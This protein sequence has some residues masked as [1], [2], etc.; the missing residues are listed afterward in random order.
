[1]RKNKVNFIT[2]GCSKNL[3]DSE[4]IMRQFVAGGYSVVHNPANADGDITVINTCGFIQ[5]AKEESIETILTFGAAKQQGRI[6]RL[7]VIGCLSERYRDQ[8]QKLIPEVDKFYGKF[9]Y[10]QL[11]T[12]LGKPYH[13]ELAGERLLSTPSHY[14][15][16]KIAEG[17]NRKCSYCSIPLITGKYRSRPLDEIINE[18]RTLAA[19]G[20][21]EFQLIAQDLTSYGRDIYRKAALSELLSRLSD[22]SGVQWLRLHYAYPGQFPADILP[23]IAER[24]NICKYLDIALQHSSDRMLKKMRRGITRE[25]TVTLI[26][27]IRVEVPGIHLRTTM[28]V[29]HPGETEEDFDDLMQFVRDTRFERLGAFIYSAE[30]KTYSATHYKDEIDAE[31]KN[32]RMDTLMSLQESIAEEINQQKTGQTLKVIIDREEPD[33]YIGRTEY[34]SPEVDAEVLV[35]KNRKLNA[36][37]FYN[38]KITGSRSFDLTGDIY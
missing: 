17:C 21:K 9:D 12:D 30:E 1:M 31:T 29:G 22:I 5:S 3:V 37:Q 14:A 25:E 11:L 23:I 27:R 6:R 28:L 2:L 13:P 36:G 7:Y 16:I 34:D 26:N 19:G 8:L 24:D 18:V 20:V 38:V 35:N 33:F 10:N 15:Y 4:Y 32:R